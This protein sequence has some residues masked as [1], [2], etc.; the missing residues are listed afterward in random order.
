MPALYLVKKRSG[1]EKAPGNDRNSTVSLGRSRRQSNTS[2]ENHCRQNYRG[3][4]PLVSEVSAAHSASKRTRP[5]LAAFSVEPAATLA[6]LG[7]VTSGPAV[8]FENNVDT[9]SALTIVL[10]RTETGPNPSNAIP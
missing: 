8:S 4:T 6:L 10:K 1:I 3:R 2:V 5:T 9:A 7:L